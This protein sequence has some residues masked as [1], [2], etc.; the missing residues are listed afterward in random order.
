MGFTGRFDK[1]L[2]LIIFEK[3]QEVKVS[4]LLCEVYTQAQSPPQAVRSQRTLNSSDITLFIRKLVTQDQ[5][6]GQLYSYGTQ[7]AIFESVVT[8]YSTCTNYLCIE[9][10]I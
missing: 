1:M 10:A 8:L 3:F 5:S 6:Y 7:E 4:Q 2:C 9:Y